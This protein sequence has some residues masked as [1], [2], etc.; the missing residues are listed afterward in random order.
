[1]KKKIYIIISL[2]LL[3]GFTLINKHADAQQDRTSYFMEAYAHKS[4]SN[5]ALI[6][7]AKFYVSFPPVLSSLYFG[8]ENSGFVFDDVLS[9]RSD[10]SLQITTDKFID[11][12]SDKNVLAFGLNE[13][14]FGFGFRAKRTYFSFSASV[15]ANANFRYPKELF[16]LL[17][18]G[19]AQFTG[20]NIEFEGIGLNANLYNEFAIGVSR[21]ITDRLNVG[22]RG[23]YL[24]GIANLWT[25]KADLKLYTGDAS[26]SYALRVNSDIIINTALAGEL[27]KMSEDDWE[28]DLANFTENKGF[29]FDVGASYR[30]GNNWN[31]SASMLDIG[32]INW[33][34]GVTNYV[35]KQSGGTFSF[36]GIDINEFVTEGEVGDSAFQNVLDSLESSLGLDEKSMEYTA[37][38]PMKIYLGAS[39]NLT[40]KDKLGALVRN[41]F[42][43]KQLNPT[44]TLSYNRQ[45]GKMLN[46][47]FSYTAKRNNYSNI[48]VG[49][50]L[51]LGAL[52]FY[53]L[54]DNFY[55]AFIPTKT[56]MVNMRFGLNLTFGRDKLSAKLVPDEEETESEG[57][58]ETPEEEESGL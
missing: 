38:L 12:L 30:F 14:I 48:G 2:I 58:E 35:S 41:E 46:M 57:I 13:E 21:Q 23:K 31:F 52:Q 50:A 32:S 19:N 3:L 44:L 17:L 18:Q 26:E 25:E 37:P 49:M 29:A 22:V 11:A 24:I 36:E 8:V 28:F 34:E 27:D 33:K 51:N 56:K 7:D 42:A 9:K 4:Y 15:K 43:V 55:S 39:Y 40:P 53:L 6:P 10:D 1:M 45:F 16:Q 47:A 54:S 5:P 20:Q